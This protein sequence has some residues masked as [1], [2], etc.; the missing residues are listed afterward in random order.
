MG[1]SRVTNKATW[2]FK[3]KKNND[4]APSPSGKA[5]DFDSPIV[6]STPAGATWE[7]TAWMLE[8]PVFMRFF[9]FCEEEGFAD[10]GR[11]EVPKAV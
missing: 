8:N 7:K 3:D 11:F 2:W 5:G 1:S 10:F 6:G 9:V 4:N